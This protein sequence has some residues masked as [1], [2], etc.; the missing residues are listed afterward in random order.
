MAFMIRLRRP[1]SISLRML[2][3][4]CVATAGVSLLCR[5]YVSVAKDD[6][7]ST[8][9]TG[10][11]SSQLTI[12]SSTPKTIHKHKADI[13]RASKRVHAAS[14]PILEFL[15]ISNN[16]EDVWD[17]LHMF[18]FSM[19]ADNCKGRAPIVVIVHTAMYNAQKRQKIRKDTS[20]S[21]SKRQ[22]LLTVV[23][24]VGETNNASLQAEVKRESQ[25]YQDIVQGNFIDSYHNL[26]HKHIMGYHWVI[27]HCKTVRYFIKIDDDVVVHVDNVLRYLLLNPIPEEYI[28]CFVWP[29]SRKRT[30]GKWAISEREYP[31]IRYPRYCSGF[32]Y[33]T[34]L[35][36][37]KRLHSASTYIKSIWIDDTYATGLLALA[38][39]TKL[40]GFPNG[41]Y[42]NGRKKPPARYK[43][44]GMFVLHR[45]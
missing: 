21:D 41:Q 37:I 20:G 42:Y 8:T 19:N 2:T 7:A 25:K 18:K 14:S 26:T 31:F 10:N 16:K 13:T 9:K 39:N 6:R 4:L 11:A 22:P 17:N 40:I 45:D 5:D 38:S 30:A 12:P 36:V 23:F 3:L 29:G 24:L 32:A 28:M 44:E 34:T 15:H 27:T 33:I 43:T 35:S 1:R